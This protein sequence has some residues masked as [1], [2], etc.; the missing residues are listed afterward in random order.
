MTRD[1]AWGRRLAQ[2]PAARVELG[3]EPIAFGCRH[4]YQKS[5]PGLAPE[6]GGLKTEDKNRYTDLPGEGN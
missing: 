3:F 4:L 2:G 5:Y 6:W 1:S